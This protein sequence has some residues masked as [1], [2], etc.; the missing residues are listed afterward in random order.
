MQFSQFSLSWAFHF[1]NSLVTFPVMPVSWHLYSFSSLSIFSIL[2]FLMLMS[3]P[4]LLVVRTSSLPNY[5]ADL[6]TS[7]CKPISSLSTEVLPYLPSSP[8]ITFSRYL[9]LH[10]FVLNFCKSNLFDLSASSAFILHCMVIV[11]AIW[12]NIFCRKYFF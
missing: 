8:F 7:S 10:I 9:S 12:T 1:E 11:W 5:S 6:I 3:W 2:V 4:R